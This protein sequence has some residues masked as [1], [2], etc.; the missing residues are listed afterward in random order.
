MELYKN[1]GASNNTRRFN[2]TFNN[3]NNGGKQKVLVETNTT[4]VGGSTH[5]SSMPILGA[6]NNT[7]DNTRPSIQELL[8]KQ[9]IFRRGM[10]QPFFQQ[11]LEQDYITLPEPK[12]PEQV[13]MIDN[14]LYC[15]YH[16]YVGH[17]IEDCVAFK[18]WLQRAIDEKRLAIPPDVV[19]PDFHMVNMIT[20]TP[21]VFITN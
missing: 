13:E 21:Q 14:P 17:I 20:V 6:W 8:R 7:G 11:V 2:T 9:Y 1:A 10:V 12:R 5:Q 16:R 18:E 19:N 3:N 4:R 15:P